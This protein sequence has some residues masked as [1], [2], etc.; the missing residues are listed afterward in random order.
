M[1]PERKEGYRDTR[2]RLF[3]QGNDS[4]LGQ[5]GGGL[6]G[7]KATLGSASN[8]SREGKSPRSYMQDKDM[9]GI[10]MLGSGQLTQ[11][12]SLRQALESSP[13]GLSPG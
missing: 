1:G 3:W 12:P 6:L 11:V 5:G 10:W 7:G 13:E 8:P 4:H 2:R 9:S